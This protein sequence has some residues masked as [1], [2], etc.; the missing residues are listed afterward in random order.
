M[1]S[2][3]TGHPH[4][5]LVPTGDSDRKTEETPSRTTVRV[6]TGHGTYPEN[7]LARVVQL[8]GVVDGPVVTCFVA[9]AGLR[10]RHQDLS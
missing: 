10:S 5:S 1:S 8:D 7:V 2:R 9:L 3:R 6:I 4:K